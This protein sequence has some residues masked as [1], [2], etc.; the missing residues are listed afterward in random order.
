M[1]TKIYSEQPLQVLQ[2]T[3]GD[4]GVLDGVRQTYHGLCQIRRYY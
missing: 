2:G 3:D 4:H 1:H